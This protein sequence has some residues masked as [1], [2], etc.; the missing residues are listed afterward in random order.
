VEPEETVIW[1]GKP[2]KWPFVTMGLPHLL[3]ALPASLAWTGFF[4]YLEFLAVRAG[5]PA[6]A[7]L[8]APFVLVGLYLTGGRF[9]AGAWCWRNTCYMIT[10]KRVLIRLGAVWPRVTELRLS[11]LSSIHIQEVR[12]GLGHINF[13]SGNCRTFDSVYVW[14]AGPSC[15]IINSLVVIVPSFRYIRGPEQVYAILN[16]LL[17][18]ARLH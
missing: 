8:L 17:A 2:E 7:L 11:E 4:I 12:C 10:D 13:S 18:G 3:V 5:S 14:Q 16:T 15:A 1:Q 6:G 9:F